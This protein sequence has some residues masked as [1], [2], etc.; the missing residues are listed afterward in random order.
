ME[1]LLYSESTRI[2]RRCWEA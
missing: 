2:C 1:N